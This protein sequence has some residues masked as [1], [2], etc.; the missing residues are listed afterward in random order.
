MRL[1]IFEAVK[2][3]K[4][5][6]GKFEIMW[7]IICYQNVNKLTCKTAS[8]TADWDSSV[9]HSDGSDSSLWHRYCNTVKLI[10][11]GKIKQMMARLIWND[12]GYYTSTKHIQTDV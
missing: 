3:N 12:V 8:R 2:Q 5:R 6:R 11:S 9:D 4:W 7:D 10:W 1:N